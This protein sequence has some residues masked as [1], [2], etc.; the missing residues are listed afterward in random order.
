MH[1]N[2][3][4]TKIDSDIRVE[5]AGRLLATIDQ[6]G[7]IRFHNVLTHEQAKDIAFVAE[8]Y[9]FFISNLIEQ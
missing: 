5:F 1:P 6:Y 2:L 3:K 8:N 9:Q 7:D 4:L